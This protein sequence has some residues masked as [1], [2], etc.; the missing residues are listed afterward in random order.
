M[1]AKLIEYVGGDIYIESKSYILDLYE[2]DVKIASSMDSNRGI[3]LEL[4][5]HV[6]NQDSLVVDIKS[7]NIELINNT[8]TYISLIKRMN[9][10][11]EKINYDLTL[12]KEDWLALRA[13]NPLFNDLYIHQIGKVLNTTL[14]IV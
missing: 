2:G 3:S 11:L 6:L 13:Y 8:Y 14:P 5:D 1:K 12:V 7:Y 9:M 4:I 10:I